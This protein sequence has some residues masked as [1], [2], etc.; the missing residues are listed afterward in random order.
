MALTFG[1]TEMDYLSTQRLGRLAT[2]DAHGSPQNNPVGYWIN[3][4]THTIDIGGYDLGRSRKFR[5]VR[6]NPQV[7]LVVDD[8]ASVDPWRVRGVEIRGTA[9]ALDD[10]EP[11]VGVM[12][13]E[14]IR[15][16][17]LWIGSWGLV[18]DSFAMHVRRATDPA[19]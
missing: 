13:P 10:T 19:A 16:T 9:E 2:V 1:S 6:G 12:S 15:I 8:I 5:N 17:P 11:P 4:N 3:R 14:V 18:D 7:C